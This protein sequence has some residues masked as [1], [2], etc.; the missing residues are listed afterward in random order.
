MSINS[1]S[2]FNKSLTSSQINDIK[3]RSDAKNDT[4]A[5]TFKVT[6]KD[7]INAQA[8]AGVR[9]KLEQKR[10]RNELKEVWE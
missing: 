6:E 1:D 10:L 8:Y 9:N 3:E 2:T 5:L 4:D 7:N